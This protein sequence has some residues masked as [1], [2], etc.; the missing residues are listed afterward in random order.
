MQSRISYF[1]KEPEARKGFRTGVSLHSHTHH[2]RES[3]SF[4]AQMATQ[5][6]AIQWYLERQQRK[7]ANAGVEVDLSRACWTPPLSAREAHEVERGQIEE[8]LGLEAIVSLSDHDNI[9]ASNLLRV[10]PGL[11]NTLVSVEWTMPYHESSFHLGIHNLPAERAAAVVRDLNEYTEQPRQERLGDIL[12]S[13][14]DDKS[15]LVVFNH[16]KWNLGFLEDQRF[17]F[18]LTDFLSRYSTFLHAFELNGLRTWRENQNVAKLAYGWNQPVISGGDRHGAEPNGN[19]NMTNA[20]SFEEFVH[21]VRVQRVSNVMFMPQYADPLELRF[22]Q[23]FMDVIREY[24][25]KPEGAHKWDGRTLHPGHDGEMVPVA[26]LWAKPPQFIETI[27]GF[28][29]RLEA[30]RAHQFWRKAGRNEALQLELLDGE[31]SA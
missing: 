7:A 26:T 11:E 4:V 28:A 24:P 9:H 29:Q 19:V 18:L 22:F 25:D 8:T 15:V 31:Q 16:P 10:I 1:W 27:L 5:Y 20:E 30:G 14:N 6:R 21:E 13:L 2:S 3:L 12:R 17:E 23:T